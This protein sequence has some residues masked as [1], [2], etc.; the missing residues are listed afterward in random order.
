[1]VRVYLDTCCLNR[2][3]DDQTQHRVRLESDAIIVILRQIARGQWTLIGS[4][5]VD[6]EVAAIP[7]PDRREKVQEF[8]HTAAEHIHV[9][10]DRRHR[11]LQ[12]EGLG[13][14]AYDALHLAC[15]EAAMADVL[16]TTDDA[17][18]RRARRLRQE[19]RVRVANPLTWLQE[20]RE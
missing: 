15:A 3:L 19:L 9:D 7:D 13:F 5:A 11:G 4:G 1:M 16:L 18:V 14:Q 20:I 8:A 6:D 2:P 10:A 17:F 12:L